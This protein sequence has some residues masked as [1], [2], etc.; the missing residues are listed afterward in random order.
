MRSSTMCAIRQLY[1]LCMLPFFKDTF[2]YVHGNVQFL[3][4]T[5]HEFF[6]LTVERWREIA[7]PKQRLNLGYRDQC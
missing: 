2:E 5:S 1:T 7:S 6:I 4:L 3:L